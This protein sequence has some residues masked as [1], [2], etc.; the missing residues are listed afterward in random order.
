MEG[1]YNKNN[2]D[3]RPQEKDYLTEITDKTLTLFVRDLSL[4]TDENNLRNF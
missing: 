4:K 2:L 3:R 1:K